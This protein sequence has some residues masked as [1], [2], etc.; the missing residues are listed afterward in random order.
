MPQQLLNTFLTGQDPAGSSNS[1]QQGISESSTSTIWEFRQ[2]AI[3]ADHLSPFSSALDGIGAS[4]PLALPSL[5]SSPVPVPSGAFVRP[6]QR[7]LNQGKRAALLT[8]QLW[9][10]TVVGVEKNE[11]VAVVND[12]T[13][14]SNPEEEVS[15]DLADVS[16]QDRS[17]VQIGASFY[18][19]IGR[20]R[21]PA[22]T[23]RNISAL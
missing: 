9:E 20:E 11:F 5:V 6:V 22:G 10:G 17:L 23:I 8:Q 19:L 3:G 14:P 15:F 1:E 18:W 2:K 13:E 12:K 4:Q 16:E 7:T 21:T